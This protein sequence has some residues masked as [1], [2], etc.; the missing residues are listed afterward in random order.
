MT[1]AT[2]SKPSKAPPWVQTELDLGTTDDRKDTAGRRIFTLVARSG[3]MEKSIDIDAETP[4]GALAELHTMAQFSGRVGPEDYS[5]IS[6][7]ES[8]YTMYDIPK[9]N[10]VWFDCVLEA[11][12]ARHFRKLL[13]DRIYSIVGRNWRQEATNDY[14]RNDIK[15][16]FQKDMPEHW[17]NWN[18][19]KVSNALSFSE[20]QK[21]EI[22][23]LTGVNFQGEFKE[24]LRRT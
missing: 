5:V 14:L 3:D 24:A 19:R 1:T 12:S 17:R 20:D 22:Q 4:V 7:K 15:S 9:K 13:W 18:W 16:R 21:Y 10:P 11:G 23:I 8:G 2:K 6:A